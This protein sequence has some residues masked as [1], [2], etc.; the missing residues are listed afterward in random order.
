M[1][2]RQF[3]GFTVLFVCILLP[4]CT[5]ATV[6]VSPTDVVSPSATTIST[7]QPSVPATIPTA[8][9]NNTV[10]PTVSLPT[11]NPEALAKTAG[12]YAYKVVGLSFTMFL[13]L[14]GT[15]ASLPSTGR[16]TVTADQITFVD[17]LPESGSLCNSE[18][19]IYQWAL[20]DSG[21]TLVPLT[22]NCASRANI[23]GGNTFEKTQNQ[24]D[25]PV[26]FMWR[27]T[28]APH[29][30][31]QPLNIAM[32]GRSN[33]YI[34]DTGNH[35]IQKFDNNGRFLTMWGEYGQGLG[36]FDFLW[37]GIHFGAVAVD[38]SGNVYV[39]D[40]N[41]RVQKFDSNGKFLLKWGTPGNGDGQF[42][43][44]SHLSV[45]VD[46]LGNVYVSDENN[47][48]IQKFDNNGQFLLKWGSKGSADGQ[49]GENQYWSG[50]QGIAVDGQGNLYVADPANYRIEKFDVNGNF[51]SQWGNQGT[52]NGQF[53]AP[54][55]LTVDQQGN[56]YVTDSQQL[57]GGPTNQISKF[58]SNGT[59]L[60]KWGE[61]G[62]GLGMLN[63]PAGIAVDTQ[64]NIYVVNVSENVQ[65][66]KQK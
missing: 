66:F 54:G 6:P 46:S 27:I 30:F 10:V 58:D 29:P 61:T 9:L 33:I 5:P 34:V 59:F 49:F 11:S 25:A 40:A 19:G 13:H 2:A 14:D 18:P 55:A 36:Q 51:I 43:L 16:F 37:Q 1:N 53:L 63:Y 31:I 32:D 12:T 48:S 56:I 47:S 26:E 57:V 28:G 62:L 35:R 17:T 8:T 41:S 20:N 15:Y 42:A 4:A 45:A 24:A 3:L 23:F 21:L 22:D 65:K 52:G 50:P 60:W 39:T 44:H 7:V 38:T 64:G